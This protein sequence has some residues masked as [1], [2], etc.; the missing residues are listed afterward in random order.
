VSGTWASVAVGLLD[1]E[2]WAPG[3]PDKE[4]WRAWAA[5]GA[6]LRDDG[7][8]PAVEAMAPAL[9]RRAGRN[10]RLGLETAWRL[11]PQGAPVVSVFGSRHGQVARSAVL[12]EALAQGTPLS[13]MDFSLSVHNAC[14]GLFSIARQ[15]RSASS[16]VAAGGEELAS[17]M[18]EAAGLLAEGAESVLLSVHDELPPAL[19]DAHWL[20]EEGTL[21][22]G[23]RLGPAGRRL[24]L[25]LMEA[26]PRPEGASQGEVLARLLARGAGTARWSRGGRAWVWEL[27]A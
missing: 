17:A 19:Y 4:A 6:G 8:S 25:S 1:W 22:L 13:P 23:L 5:G 12:L 14:A 11:A 3:L 15:D 2:A 16:A 24:R 26:A 21:G 27:D 7:S 10:D 18:L 9:R 20:R